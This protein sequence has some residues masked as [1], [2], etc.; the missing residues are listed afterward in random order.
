MMC[1]IP[2]SKDFRIEET[3][4]LRSYLHKI[5]R[6][7]KVQDNS[8]AHLRNNSGFLKCN[9]SLLGNTVK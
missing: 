7:K 1:D 8:R 3:I 4:L 2:G 5:F 9:Y 6:I